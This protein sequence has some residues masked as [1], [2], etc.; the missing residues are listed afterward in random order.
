MIDLKIGDCLEKMKDMEDCSVDMI[1]CDPPYELGFM[2]KKWDNTGIAFNIKVWEEALR[3]L[4]PGGYLMAFS[5]SRTYHRMAV[6][7]EDAGFEVKDMIE[8]VYGSGFPKSLDVSKAIDKKLGKD[9]EII[10]RNPNSRE[11]CSKENTLY[12]SG[13]VGKTDY[14]TAPASDLAKQYEGYKTQLK[15]AHEP[16]I[17]A[18]KKFNFVLNYDI[19]LKI[20][21]ILEVI[22]ECVKLYVKGVEK[23]SNQHLIEYQEGINIV[24]KNV[25]TVLKE[26]LSEKTDTFK[27]QET[28]KMC[29]SID[30]LW[31]NI[32]EEV[33]IN[34]NI[35]TIKTESNLTTELKTLKS[36][37]LTDIYENITQVQE[38]K[39]NGLN[40]D[41]MNAENLSKEERKK[42]IDTLNVIVPEN[43]MKQIEKD[44]L[45]RLVSFAEK[46]LGIMTQIKNS[47]VKTVIHNGEEGNLQI[48]L[49]DNVNIAEKNLKQLNQDQ[50][51]TV[52]EN[53]CQK[54]L[55][56]ANHEPICLAMKP[57]SEKTFANNVMKWGTGGLN[58][59]GSRVGNEKIKTNGGLKF[60]CEG[61]YNKYDE[62]FTGN[63]HEGRYP[64]NL[65]L[66]ENITD[67][68]DEQSGIS[69]SSPNIL[70]EKYKDSEKGINTNFNR[71]NDTYYN[72]EGGASRYFKNIEEEDNY[73]PFI[74]HAKASKKDRNIDI[75]GEQITGEAKGAKYYLNS[76]HRKDGTEIKSFKNVNNHATVKPTGLMKYLLKMG[77]P[78]I[79][80]AVVL[81]MF[82]GSGSTGVALEQ[83]NKEE[84]T[85][86][87]CILIEKEE[88]H[89]EIIKKRCCLSK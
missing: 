87:T 7:I 53:V 3:V 9:R 45:K 82:A 85:E 33:L 78:P 37:L 64:A 13:T 75:N 1:L 56:R 20:N 10:C 14:I 12:E 54:D 68:L 41:V 34:G 19:M 21:N 2:G 22:S 36:Q 32:S 71:G 46:S 43:V 30:T 63:T 29:W 11:N 73:I 67:V 49:Y 38:L 48:E 61:I 39:A 58:I 26:E 74:Y 59:D 18:Q 23:K 51:N 86:H 79:K 17:L 28:G 50:L 83:L 40:V 55:K 44:C 60:K 65:I 52:I 62:N 15:P 24:L 4:K 6:A 57:L 66:H 27:L 89:A 77:L 8:W 31:N 69:K 25:E 70:K 80:D 81:D 35:Y 16:L 72:D 47:V 84:G 88:E 76:T 5:G 42:L